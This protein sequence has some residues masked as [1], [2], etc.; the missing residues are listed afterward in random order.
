MRSSDQKPESARRRIVVPI[1][2]RSR[3]S[4]ARIPPASRPSP[5]L[6]PARKG[7]A[8]R[9]IA[10][11]GVVIGAILLALSAGGFLWWQ[12]YKTTPAYS[13]ALLVDAAQR[14]DMPG[15]DKIVD[16]DKI[17]E[18]LAAQ[19][20]DKAA[21]RYGAALSGDVSKTIR[22]RVPALLPNI[23][24]E[25]RDAVASRVKEISVKADQKPFLVIAVVLPYF[26]KITTTGG[27]IAD[28]RITIQD[29]P[30]VLGLTRSGDFWRVVSVQDA[31]LVERL[32]DEVIKD[33]PAIAPNIEADIR[34][35][36]RK[37][38]APIRIP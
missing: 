19:V 33:L 3:G 30:V 10:I 1:G 35:S 16:T 15:V 13:L 37:P 20:I 4:K 25:V 6:K 28:A 38:R 2:Q 17:V 24:Q 8:G 18:T 34:K 14:N 27:E 7:R 23:K 9:V 29:K 26:V 32:V 11:L 5:R 21:G 22:A 12:H 36:L 31:A